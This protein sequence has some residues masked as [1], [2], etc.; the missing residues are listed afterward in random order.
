MSRKNNWRFT[1]I[2][3]PYNFVP[4]NKKV[5][6]PPWADDISHDV[7]FSDGESG[8]IKITIE[9]KS[10]IFI[11]NHYQEGD[12]YYTDKE[13]NKISKEFC[14]TKTSDGAKQFYIPGSSLKGMIRSVLEIM[15]FSKIKVDEDKLKKPLSVR[16]MT[17]RKELVGQ[18][19]GCG[20]LI[21][22]NGEYY[23][24]D[25][26]KILTIPYYEIKKFSEIDISNIENGA[27]KYNLIQN[28]NIKFNKKTKMMNVRGKSIPKNY[29]VYNKD[30][31]NIGKLVFTNKIKNKKNEFVF[32]PNGNKINIDNNIVENFKKVYFE[33]KNS[34]LGQYWKGKN[35]IP[36]FYQ[37]KGDN[38]VAI[39][40]TQIFKLAYNK[41][42]FEAITQDIDDSKLDLAESI[43]GSHQDNLALKG[44]VQ[45]SHFKSNIQRYEKERE[46][47]QV[48]GEPKPTYYP[49]YI[50][51]TDTN[52]D[53][54]RRYKTLM[55]K[56]VQIA[57]YKRY[58]LQP[59]TNTSQSGNDNE[60]IKTHFKPLDRETK[61]IGKV[62]FHN[63]KKA[64]L[65]ALISA[66]TFHGQENTHYH[67]IG[68]AKP[69]GYG[70][71]EIKIDYIKTLKYEDNSLEKRDKKSY[72]KEFEECMNSWQEKPYENW[73]N[74][75]QLKELFAMS[76]NSKA[77]SLRYQLLENE[78]G[79][80][81]FVEAKKAKKYLQPYT[82]L[83]TNEK[84][85]K[86]N[87][88]RGLTIVR[89]KNKEK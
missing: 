24:Q 28:R 31:S 26:G 38:I 6:Y 75:P 81:E 45:F 82:S 61:F 66:L 69:L 86:K 74:S 78:E 14:Y 1:M 17:N 8:E 5:F 57:G 43:F 79:K 52:G 35:N 72:L 87:K 84:V 33:D 41:T 44:R 73:I 7:P 18:A 88:K 34:T 71:I 51:Q 39:G 30:S 67:N 62:R 80:N 85:I 83:S 4:L 13:G 2:K 68:M 11:R 63:L 49:N 60:D 37:K 48:L 3:A 58:P 23:I 10:P 77:K 50:K 53:K 56:D 89:K 9:A 22:D 46:V 15:S 40:L 55:D 65:G 25:C 54:V 42:L 16:D 64:E 20:F 29:A 19:N 12:E 76:D 36:I 27:E 47:E 21:K 32:K 59:N 70:K